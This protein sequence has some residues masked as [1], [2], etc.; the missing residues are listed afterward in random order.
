MDRT[1]A[2][3]IPRAALRTTLFITSARKILTKPSGD[4]L[5]GKSLS[6]G[7]CAKLPCRGNKPGS[8]RLTDMVTYRIGV[9]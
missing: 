9:L 1:L 5:W 6:S 3:R 7:I 2:L 8:S 4:P